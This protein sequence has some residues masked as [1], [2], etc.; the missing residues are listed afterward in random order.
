MNAFK[1]FTFKGH[2]TNGETEISISDF[3]KV[4]QLD[5]GAGV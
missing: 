4:I 2:F 1:K 3:L 5:V